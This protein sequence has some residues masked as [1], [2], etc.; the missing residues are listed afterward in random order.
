MRVH[1]AREL[2][3]HQLRFG[4]V[5]ADAGAAAR[6]RHRDHVEAAALAG[7]HRRQPPANRRWPPRARGTA[8]CARRDRTARSRARSP[9]RRPWPRPRAHRPGWRTRACRHR[10]APRPGPA[11][12]RSARAR[13]RCRRSASGGVG[14]SSASSYLMPL[15][16]RSRRIARPPMTWPSASMMRPASVG[17][18]HGEAHAA[19]AQR[20]D[21][22]LH[23]AGRIGLEPGAEGEHALR[24]VAAG[25][26]RGIADD[27]G[28]VGRRR[29]GDEDLRLREQQAIGAVDGGLGCDAL[30]ARRCSRPR[31][32]AGACAPAG[33]R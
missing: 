20:I 15:T 2:G 33:S 12:R 26:Q 24:R 6:G 27:F 1:H 13:P 11:P 7:D 28:L 21:R 30:V 22:A 19:R 5:D 29:P 25:D 23:V 17:H 3:A 18:R 9:R 4:R 16:S 10:R 32:G 31:R 14:S 8:R